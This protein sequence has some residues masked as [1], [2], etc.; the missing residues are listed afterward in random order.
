[1]TEKNPW[2][3]IVTPANA[4]QPGSQWKRDGAA[5]KGKLSIRPIATE[6][7][8]ALACFVVVWTMVPLLIWTA[9]FIAGNLSLEAAILATAA[10]E[11]AAV[12]GFILLLWAKSRRLKA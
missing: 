7:W 5:S 8:L 12:G 9:G 4:N 6:G 3:L 1:M 11:I 10:F 2:F